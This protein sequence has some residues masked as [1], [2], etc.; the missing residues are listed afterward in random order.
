M[1]LLFLI[2]SGTHK[3]FVCDSGTQEKK[4]EST[5]PEVITTDYQLC[6]DMA[7]SAALP[8]CMAT[9]FRQAEN[10]PLCTLLFT[11]LLVYVLLDLFSLL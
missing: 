3:W 5:V 7:G 6:T 10:D 4:V 1:S 11:L 2:S 8:A 9:V